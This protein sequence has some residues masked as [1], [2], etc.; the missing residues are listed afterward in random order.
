MLTIHF[1]LVRMQQ[2]ADENRSAH[3]H[4]CNLS[5]ISKRTALIAKGMIEI[6]R[7]QKQ[8]MYVRY[9]PALLIYWIVLNLTYLIQSCVTIFPIRC[10]DFF[11]S[12]R[13]ILLIAGTYFICFLGLGLRYNDLPSGR[14]E[15]KAA[16]Q[17]L[18]CRRIPAI[19]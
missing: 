16:R 14:K 9:F 3:V 12:L 10:K 5:H 13:I 11:D 17:R 7:L 8:I 4:S 15:K 6:V 19:R 1:D 2:L 18:K